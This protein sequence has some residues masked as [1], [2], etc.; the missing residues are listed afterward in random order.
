MANFFYPSQPDAAHGEMAAQRVY[1]R[2]PKGKAVR[3]ATDAV[4]EALQA[5]V[6][7]T[8]E[9]IS[10]APHGPGSYSISLGTDQGR[11]LLRLDRQGARLQSVEVGG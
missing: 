1:S 11:L 6:G 3:A 8:I 10:V 5:L 7:Q 2:T 4:T 9:E